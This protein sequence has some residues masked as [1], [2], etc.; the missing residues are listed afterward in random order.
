MDQARLNALTIINNVVNLGNSLTVEYRKCTH[1]M[2]SQ[3]AS[4]IKELAYG[5]I[6]YKLYIDYLITEI[7][8]KQVS[9]MK[10]NIR[11]L[12]RMSIYQLEF[13]KKKEY[14]VVSESVNIVKKKSSKDTGFVNWILREYL[15]NKKEIHIKSNDKHSLSKKYSFPLHLIEYLTSK[16]G[17]AKTE[18]LLE[19]YNEKSISYAFNI[20]NGTFRKMEHG[21]TPEKTEYIIDRAY[22]EIFKMLKNI[23]FTTVL[24]CCA[25]PGGKT[26][27]IKHINP[28]SKVMAMDIN[29]ERVND[30]KANIDRLGLTG[31]EVM[32]ADFLST[33]LMTMYDLIIIDVP[34]SATGTIRKNPDVKYNYRKKLSTLIDIQK[35]ILKRST[36]FLKDG[37]YLF[38]MTCSII[39][40]ENQKIID[41]F[42]K[43]NREYALESEYF[44]Y[45][46]P[47][48]GAYAALIK[49]G[50]GG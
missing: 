23:E 33:E 27:L 32:T 40:N 49:N 35:K 43:S 26:I 19:Y 16:V 37:G 42:L 14:A 29:L 15:R 36:K 20:S 7:T 13:M 39:E 10:K 3:D 30:I 5:T 8:G 22:F 1:S 9:D 31:I 44:S 21:D 50:D 48:S 34:C 47:Y 17:T 24:D 4:L 18:E 25:A 11:N 45:G 38:Y 2:N 46:N 12:V 28:L 6:R 41:E